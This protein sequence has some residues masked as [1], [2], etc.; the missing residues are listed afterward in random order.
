MLGD[1]LAQNFAVGLDLRSR[2]TGDM[3]VWNRGV[4]GCAL[5]R[6]GYRWGGAQYPP[7]C[8]W[9]ASAQ[10]RREIDQFK[11][12]V[13]LVVAGLNDIVD[14]RRDEWGSS[15]LSPGDPRFDSWLLS[16]YQAVADAMGRN[17]VPVV[18]IPPPCLDWDAGWGQM[19][20]ADHNG[21]RRRSHH[22]GTTIP[23]LRTTRPVHV[24]DVESQL[25]PG[26]RFDPNAMGMQDSRPDG[27]HLTNEASTALAERWL[28]PLLF[29]KHR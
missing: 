1:S 19:V 21:E 5:G 10:A 24:G 11:P 20:G 13:V 26:G 23:A 18:W 3:V 8:S 6:G 12:T 29:S 17:G 14:R 22:N 15:Y 16:E 9:W 2:R 27:L 7:E 4:S 28:A 25:C